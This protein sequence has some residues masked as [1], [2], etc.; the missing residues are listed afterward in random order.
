MDPGVGGSS[1]LFHPFLEHVDNLL[2]T[3]PRDGG[4]AIFAI[5]YFYSVRVLISFSIVNSQ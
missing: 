2:L 4:S 1:P 5:D 3:P